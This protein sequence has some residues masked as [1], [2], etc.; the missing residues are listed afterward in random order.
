MVVVAFRR[1]NFGGLVGTDISGKQESWFTGNKFLGEGKKTWDPCFG[2]KTA[3]DS[4]FTT[5]NVEVGTHSL[6]NL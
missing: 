5:N 6:S 3:M 1:T 4:M 2:P